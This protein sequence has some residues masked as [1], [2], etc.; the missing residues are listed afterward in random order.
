MTIENIIEERWHAVTCL[1]WFMTLCVGCVN[2]NQ[3]NDTVY[4]KQTFR[5]ICFASQMLQKYQLSQTFLN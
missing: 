1:K 2:D 4:V 5:Y 3:H